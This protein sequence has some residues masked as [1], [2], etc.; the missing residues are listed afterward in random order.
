MRGASRKSAFGPFSTLRLT[1]A[2]ASSFLPRRRMDAL[3]PSASAR[4][5]RSWFGSVVLLPVCAALVLSDSAMTMVGTASVFLETGGEALLG[6]ASARLAAV[7]LLLG[8]VAV[9]AAL[10]AF[11][12]RYRFCF[13]MQVVLVW[14]GQNLLFLG[15][16]GPENAHWP[17]LLAALGFEP[18]DYLLASGCML[19]GVLA[20]VAA[21]GLPALV[22]E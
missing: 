22:E 19:L 16:F 21:L 2:L 8:P 5:P 18:F 20:F 15:R 4:S 1:P 13:G 7:G 12:A 6:L 10:L 11:F 17:E 14:L 9:P 3:Y